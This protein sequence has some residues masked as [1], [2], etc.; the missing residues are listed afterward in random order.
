MSITYCECVFEAL[1]IQHAMRM[2]H[3]VVFGLSGSTL[4]FP[5]YPIYSKIF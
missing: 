4:C 3:I 2:L 1:G 5:H